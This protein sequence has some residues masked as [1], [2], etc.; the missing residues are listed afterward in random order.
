MFSFGLMCL[1]YVLFKL[2]SGVESLAIYLN[3]LIYLY[4]PT[5]HLSFK[6]KSHVKI[7]CWCISWCKHKAYRLQVYCIAQQPWVQVPLQTVEVSI[8]YSQCFVC[9]LPH[10]LPS[11]THLIYFYVDLCSFCLLLSFPHCVLN[12]Q[13]C[14]RYWMHHILLSH[15]LRTL[16]VP[17]T[18]NIFCMTNFLNML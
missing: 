10:I 13:C 7:L 9:L 15:M 2:V 5:L 11:L 3:K 12:S 4:T 8:Y 14:P 17:L 6:P 18:L 1:I 16:T